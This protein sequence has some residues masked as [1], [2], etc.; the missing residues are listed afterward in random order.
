MPVIPPI[1]RE[2]P[3]HV[4]HLTKPFR[5]EPPLKCLVN[6]LKERKI[7]AFNNFGLAREFASNFRRAHPDAKLRTQKTVCFTAVPLHWLPSVCRR[8]NSEFGLGFTKSWLTHKNGNHVIYAEKDKPLF[9]AFKALT[10]EARRSPAARILN[11]LDSL[12]LDPQNKVLVTRIISNAPVDMS[13]MGMETIW[14]ITPFVDGPGEYQGRSYRFDWEMEWRVRGSLTFEDDDVE[15][16]VMPE[17]YHDQVRHLKVTGLPDPKLVK[18]K[19]PSTRTYK[20]PIIDP[21]WE[22]ER[23]EE[24]FESVRQELRLADEEDFFDDI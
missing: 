1:Y 7:S 11:L 16:L 14:A 24:E 4:V 8:R 10:D 22:F 13:A 20:C 19:T 5:G 2:S 23:I 9:N 15:L 18:V 3:S 6:I 21:N 17:K 12:E